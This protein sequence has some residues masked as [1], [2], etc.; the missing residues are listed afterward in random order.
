V[1]PHANTLRSAAPAAD[2]QGHS[3]T[4]PVLTAADGSIDPRESL[5]LLFRDLRT[6]ALGLSAR[7][8]ERR[9][10]VYGPNE[11]PHRSGRRWPGELLKQVTHPLAL[12]LVVA[13]VLAWLTGTPV[14]A[15]AIVAV[16]LLNAGF[17]FVQE[18]QA[19]RAVEALAAYLPTHARVI[20][21]GQKAEVEARTLVPGDVLLISE[22]N[23]VCADAR[24][25][26]GDLQVDLSTLTGESLP[27][28]RS[29]DQ[30]DTTG[31]ALQARELVFSGT[32][33]IEG[34]ARAVVT[35][36]GALTELGRIAA[37]SQRTGRTD[38][39]LERQVK[40][41]AWL[42]ALVAV[43][44]GLVFL[45]AGVAAGLSWAAAATFAIGLIVANVPEGL[46]PTITLALAVG[47]RDL[48]RRGA[49]VKRL[50]AVE[51]LGSTTVICTDKTGTLT[52]NKMRVTKVW[53]PGGEVDLESGAD[54]IDSPE[55][56]TL[57]YTS[58][59]CTSAELA[60][61]ATASAIGDPTEL[62]LLELART[63]GAPLEPHA[64][65]AGRRAVFHFDPHLLRMSTIDVE[66]DATVALH[67]KG[68]PETV[69]PWC[70][71]ITEAA[72]G[73]RELTD[74]DRSRLAKLIDQYATQGLRILAIAR[75]RI[76]GDHVIG[77]ARADADHV[78]G[79]ARADAEN[80]LCLLGLVMMFDPP[81]LQVR[82]AIVQA[83]RAGIRI[84]VV[85]GDNGLTAAEIARRVGIG[86]AGTRIV[87][88]EQLDALSEPE[89]DELLSRDEEI[90]FAR[91]SPEVKL[92]IADALRARG[93][94][95]AMTGDGV[96]DAPALHRADIGVAMGRSGTD[97]AR[98]AATMVLTDDDFGTI[99]VAI[100][101][102]RRVYD[103]IRKFILYIFTHAVPEVVPFLVFAV[104]GGAIPLP[105]TVLQILAIDLG[106]DI[107]PALAL[108]REPAEPG[109]MDRSPRPPKEGIIRGSMLLRAWAFLGAISAVLVMGGFLL[110]LHGA[111]WHPGAPTGIGAPLHHAYQQA[112]TVAWLGIVA[113]QIGTGFA[114]RTDHAS[115]RAIGVFSNPALLGGI[116][117][118]IVFALTLVYTPFL[119]PVFGTAALSAGQLLLVV[120]FPLIVWGADE[121]RRLWRRRGA[122]PLGSLAAPG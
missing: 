34:E 64:R 76:D 61:A 21:D 10:I 46:L 74:L 71:T 32:A 4:E 115:L 19:E 66:G 88:G 16:I 110:V 109:L 78:I 48:A 84:H 118:E 43:G 3:P 55:M 22:G 25:I 73:Q 65:D 108:S 69:L 5:N 70:T 100:E 96:N 62:A 119:H 121:L 6:S 103:N 12:V 106:T 58:A 85:T 51:T 89:L 86:S 99:I 45:P 113:C 28:A 95:V 77:L 13:A 49:V 79:L 15:A 57:A 33:C 36:T 11:L 60:S 104:S 75:R 93:Q 8:A 107:L 47:V 68:A 87:T 117:A 30:I 26:D 105:L 111:G 7:E 83:H 42:I 91:S 94:V 82:D 23:R 98:E 120:P 31:P 24:I 17:A 14:L 44:S 112:T 56:R 1:K 101:E 59:V 39:P 29:A 116:A 2:P 81:R 97:V 53:L 35:A 37:L 102:G 50:S 80:G 72:G 27:A 67:T 18:V 54:A 20:R 114:A 90:I 9:L 52:E 41:V 63:V 122:P 92:R 40:R 38:S